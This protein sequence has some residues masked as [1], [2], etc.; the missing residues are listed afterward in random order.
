MGA[1]NL[2]LVFSWSCQTLSTPTARMFRLL[3]G[4]PGP[5]ISIAAAAS[6]AATGRDQ[7]RRALDEL[8]AA[9]LLTEHAHDRYHLHDLLRAYAAEQAQAASYRHDV[10]A[11]PLPGARSLTAHGVSSRSGET[12]P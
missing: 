12:S 7:A 1:A 9:H 3:G 8:T 5:D 10:H 11:R 6:L 2:R 4:Y